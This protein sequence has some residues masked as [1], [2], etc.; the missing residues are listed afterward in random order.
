MQPPIT[1]EEDSDEEGREDVQ[2]PQRI[3]RSPPKQ[4]DWVKVSENDGETP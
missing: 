3:E 4:L 2:R 1:D